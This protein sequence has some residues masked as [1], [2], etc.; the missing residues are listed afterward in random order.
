MKPLIQ[1]AILFFI[2][3]KLTHLYLFSYFENLEKNNSTEKVRNADRRP[4]SSHIVF[5]NDLFLSKNLRLRFAI[6]ILH[7]HIY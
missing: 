2:L 3:I 7:D 6:K 5:K 1:S 4:N